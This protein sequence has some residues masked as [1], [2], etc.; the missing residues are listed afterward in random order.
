MIRAITG[1]ILVLYPC[2]VFS[3]PAATFSD[4]ANARHKL[5]LTTFHWSIRVSICIKKLLLGLVHWMVLLFFIVCDTLHSRRLPMNSRTCIP[6]SLSS[7]PL[8][9]TNYSLFLATDS[10][11]VAALRHSY[12][13]CL[14]QVNYTHNQI[15][16]INTQT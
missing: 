15:Y 4:W 8:N 7:T 6:S 10:V 1:S 9:I 3:L 11:P 2:S 13:T 5:S 16:T 12:S 14:H